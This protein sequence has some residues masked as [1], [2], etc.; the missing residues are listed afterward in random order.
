MPKPALQYLFKEF[1]DTAELV[2]F[3]NKTK[4]HVEYTNP[5]RSQFFATN[6]RSM[7]AIVDIVDKRE[8][9]PA[10]NYLLF[11]DGE[12]KLLFWRF[13]GKTII[14]INLDE[15]GQDT[16]YDIKVHIFTSS[17]AFHFF[18]ES[19]LFGYLIKSLFNRIL[20]D[21]VDATQKLTKSHDVFP[22]GNPS[23]IEDL[24]IRLK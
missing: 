11:E 1:P 6:N 13:N 18:F 21:I 14:E 24:L 7:R 9:T 16:K 15:F 20:G 19:A 10:S 17:R 23:F 2:N 3:Y 22:T 8:T 4:Y 5:Q 12:A